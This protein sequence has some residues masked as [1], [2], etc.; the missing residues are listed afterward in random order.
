VFFP[1]Y[2]ALI[3]IF[4]FF[5]FGNFVLAGWMVSMVSFLVAV[6]LFRKY[7]R[8]FHPDIDRDLATAFLLAFPTAFF[9]NTI[10]TESLF[11]A[12]SLFAFTRAKQGDF[13][14]AGFFGFLASLTR[15]TGILLL[16]PMIWE[17]FRQ[18]GFSTGTLFS[19]KIVPLLF[20][21]L[22]IFAFFLFHSFAF[23]DFLLFFKV[24]AA[25]GRNFSLNTDHFSLSTNPAITNFAI[26]LAHIF[27]ALVTLFWSIRKRFFDYALLIVATLSIALGSGTFMSINRYVLTLFP[28]FIAAA[29]VKNKY[30]VT[31]APIVSA[32]FCA[33]SI[34]L[35]VNNYW[36]G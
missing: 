4:S 35:F 36:A 2:P 32:L 30:F 14:Q 15:V 16:L 20:I 17:Y 9:F 29:S 31:F 26:D 8:E 18:H 33:L 34:A 19:R 6:H 25:W 10:Y 1:L 13:F 3:R 21:P 28:I 5:T 23:G 11:L 7:M 24:E 27:I 12:L 22:G